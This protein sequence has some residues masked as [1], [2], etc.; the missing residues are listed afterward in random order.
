VLYTA[1]EVASV[2]GD[3]LT[4]TRAERVERPVADEDGMHVALDNVVVARRA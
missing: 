3:D 2:V 1:D 4:V